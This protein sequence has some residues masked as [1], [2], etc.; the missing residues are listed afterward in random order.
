MTPRVSVCV[1]LFVLKNLL[2]RKSLREAFGRGASGIS[3]T[4]RV[5]IPDLRA[6]FGKKC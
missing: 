3:V 4:G 5:W 2:C 1:G 6:K